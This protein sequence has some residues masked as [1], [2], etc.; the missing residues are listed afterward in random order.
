MNVNVYDIDYNEL[1]KIAKVSPYTYNLILTLINE[2]IQ[3]LHNNMI[4]NLP[5]E[6]YKQR[7]DFNKIYKTSCMI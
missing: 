4:S 1:D 6:A 7:Q 2:K 5:I 3:N